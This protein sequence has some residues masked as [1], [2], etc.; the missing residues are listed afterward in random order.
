MQDLTENCKKLMRA[1]ISQGNLKKKNKAGRIALSDI[2]P[3][4]IIVLQVFNRA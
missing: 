1:K 3:K 4:A 2:K